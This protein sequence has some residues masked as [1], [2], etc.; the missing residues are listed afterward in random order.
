L[1][2]LDVLVELIGMDP[3]VDGEV[4]AGWLEVLPDGDDVAGVAVV[5]SHGDEVV[6]HF[7]DFLFAFADADHDSGFS[8]GALGFDTGEEFH[9]SFVLCAWAD[10]GVAAFDGF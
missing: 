4:V 8:D 1:A 9:G 5:R 6:E 7:E 3:A 2:D 10:G